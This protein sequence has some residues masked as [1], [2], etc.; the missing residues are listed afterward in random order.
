MLYFS[1]WTYRVNKVSSFCAWR[2]QWKWNSLALARCRSKCL[3]YPSSRQDDY[4]FKRVLVSSLCQLCFLLLVTADELGKYGGTG[5]MGA[6]QLL[7]GFQRIVLPP[8]Q[9]N[10]SCFKREW[11]AS[12]FLEETCQYY[13]TEGASLKGQQ[14]ENNQCGSSKVESGCI[15]LYL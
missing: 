3:L 8:I 10:L 4:L 7:E 15:F 1:S 6:Q 9:W 2:Q 13:Q 11:E 12:R 5:S 14:K